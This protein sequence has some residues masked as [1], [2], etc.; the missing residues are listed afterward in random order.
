[1]S[2]RIKTSEETK[3]FLEEVYGKALAPNK[4]VFGAAG[5]F[6]GLNKGLPPNYK[7]DARGLELLED[8]ILGEEL[9][10]VFKAALNYRCGKP[11]DD[12]EYKKYFKMY[13]DYGCG[14]L[15]DIWDECDGNRERFYRE[16]IKQ[17]KLG[18]APPESTQLNAEQDIVRD[19]IRIKLLRDVNE[20]WVLNKAGGN[21]IIVTSGQTGSGKSQLIFDLLAQV[22]RQGLRFL[23]IDLKGEMENDEDNEKQRENRRIFFHV[24]KSEYVRLIDNKLPINPLR[25]GKTDPEKSQI[26]SEVFNLIRAFGPQAGQKQE[27]EFTEAYRALQTPDFQSLKD[28]MEMRSGPDGIP[29]SIVRKIVNFN[30]FSSARDCV[31]IEEWLNVSR[32]IDFKGLGNDKETKS[33]VVALI[34]NSLMAQLNKTIPVENNIQPMKM[35][36]FVDEAHLL[37]PREGKSGL[38]GPLARQGRGWGF[39]LWLA[40]QDAEALITKGKDAADFTKQASWGF[41]FSPENLNPSQQKSILGQEFRGKLEKGEALIKHEGNIKKGV[42]RQFWRDK[43][44]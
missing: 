28:E 12:D 35:I 7:S 40:S 13:Y 42:V 26:A 18:E 43:G 44:E 37:L 20:E 34:L 24:T 8:T 14:L 5:L 23:F 3:N 22:A 17:S 21:S 6:M 4:A 16:I 2:I 15:K 33:L 25:R 9:P 38:L 1:M 30:I 29:I 39:P 32:V 19:E 31:S 41:H 36:L 10:D 27:G 11:L